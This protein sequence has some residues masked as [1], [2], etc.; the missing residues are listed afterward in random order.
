[1]G[2]DRRRGFQSEPERNLTVN[3]LTLTDVATGRPV[4]QGEWDDQRRLE[5]R[6]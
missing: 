4:R 6:L 1:M 5:G 3:R 2:S